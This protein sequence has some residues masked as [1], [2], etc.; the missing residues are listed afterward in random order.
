[1]LQGKNLDLLLIG[2]I[3]QCNVLDYYGFYQSYL[4]FYVQMRLQILYYFFP[5]QVK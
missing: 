4:T 2:L 1:M 5:D 3:V